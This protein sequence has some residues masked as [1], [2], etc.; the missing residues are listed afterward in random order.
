MILLKRSCMYKVFL[1][2]VLAVLVHTVRQLCTMRYYT[3]QDSWG[4]IQQLCCSVKEVLL[5]N[6]EQALENSE[7][8]ARSF[9]C[10]ISTSAM[11]FVIHCSESIEKSERIIVQKKTETLLKHMKSNHADGTKKSKVLD[12]IFL[13][14]LVPDLRKR[15]LVEVK[16]M[17]YTGEY[18]SG[19]TDLAKQSQSTE[20]DYW[21]HDISLQKCVAY[22]KICT[23][24]LSVTEELAAKNCSLPSVA[25]PANV[26]S[27]GL[28]ENEQV[29]LIA[30]FCISRLDK[31][32]SENNFSWDD[33]MNFRLYF[34][35]NHNI[36]H[37]T[38]SAIFSDV[39]NELVQMSRRNKVDAEPIL[40]IVPV[41]GAGR[42]LSTLDDIFTCELIASKC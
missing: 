5:R 38:L 31:V 25:C 33:V 26:M 11:V 21:G 39:F 3:W 42:S 40:N 28:V 15:A 8:V 18:L 34:A 30:R 1:A 32:L 41:L 20:Q 6:L 27:K 22:G 14:V 24:I 36:S 23:V 7:A 12:P 16:P 10:S 4:L 19:P 2:G 17:F 35:S 29:I 37:G 13:Y 9:N